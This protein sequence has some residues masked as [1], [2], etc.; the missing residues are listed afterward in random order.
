MVQNERIKKT[1]G[2]WMSR[3]T[4]GGVQD[5]ETAVEDTTLAICEYGLWGLDNSIMSMSNFLIL[6]TVLLCKDISLF[7]SSRRTIYG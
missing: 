6:I 1:S 2:N 7:L 3:V 5:Q 4:P